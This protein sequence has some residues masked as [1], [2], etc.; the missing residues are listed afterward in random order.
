MKKSELRTL[1]R[2]EIL[3]SSY[4][5][6]TE[7]V[8]PDNH[9]DFEHTRKNLWEFKDRKGVKQFLIIHQSLHKGDTK[10]EIKFGWIDENGKERY[11]KPSSY[12]ARIFNTHVFILLNEIIKHYSEYFDEFYLEAVDPLRHRLY[13]QTLNTFLDK[14]KYK[15]ERATIKTNPEKKDEIMKKIAQNIEENLK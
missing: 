11:D 13:R 4:E 6:M 10:A 5:I 9:Y 2:E 12:D 8:N 1:V 15:L 3:V 14:I 7:S